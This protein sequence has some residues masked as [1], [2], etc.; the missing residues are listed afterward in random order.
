LSRAGQISVTFL[1][2]GGVQASDVGLTVAR[3]EIVLT[4]R[5]THADKTLRRA[6][7]NESDLAG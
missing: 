5:E 4:S 7:L 3:R 1:S 6:E 2:P